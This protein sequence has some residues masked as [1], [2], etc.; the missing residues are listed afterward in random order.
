MWQQSFLAP[1]INLL[2][3]LVSPAKIIPNFTITNNYKIHTTSMLY[4]LGCAA[5]N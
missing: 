5:V 1:A 2:C 4:A 3:H